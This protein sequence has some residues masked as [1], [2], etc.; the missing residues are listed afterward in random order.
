MEE[1]F[2]KVS[3][4]SEETSFDVFMS[5]LEVGQFLYTTSFEETFTPK[6]LIS[7]FVLPKSEK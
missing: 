6:V 1:I 4:R 5:Y 3:E 2:A 7:A